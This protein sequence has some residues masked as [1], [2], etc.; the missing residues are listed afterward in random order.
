M[1][2]LRALRDRFVLFVARRASSLSF[3][4][5][6]VTGV[7]RIP[8]DRPLLIVANHWNGFVDPVLVAASIRRLPHYLARATLWKIW[9]L[10]PLLAL[11]G[12]IPVHRRADAADTSANRQAFAAAHRVLRRPAGVVGIFP[13]GITHDEPRLAAVKT[14]AARIA[15]GARTEGI[16]AIAVVPVGITYDDK[17]A[18]RSRVLVRVGRPIDVDEYVVTHRGAGDGTDE[19]HELVDALTETIR[20]GLERVTL[21]YQGWWEHQELALAS[22]VVLR[23]RMDLALN[24]VPLGARERLA[25]ELAGRPDGARA[26]VQTALN[27]YLTR[28]SVLG[29]HDRE[30]VPKGGLGWLVTRLILLAVV[31]FFVLV[32]LLPALLVNAV[33]AGAV[34]LASFAA[35]VPATRGTIRLLTGIVAFPVAWLTFALF[36]ADDWPAV[37]LVFLGCAAVAFLAVPVAEG[38][39]RWWRVMKSYVLQRDRRWLVPTVLDARAAVITAVDD[40]RAA[41][42]TAPEA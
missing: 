9:P 35:T 5:W 38:V 31:A 40:A 12:M 2:V 26:S 21:E 14:G 33:P 13:E 3:R 36:V 11:A 19:D 1:K 41:A 34:A 32:F 7:D 25:Q 39:V 8:R 37:L 22:E 42:A 24:D 6:E 10:R 20:D 28:L 4:S 29:V 18:L 17:L 27:R 16:G 15:L 30:L 23:E